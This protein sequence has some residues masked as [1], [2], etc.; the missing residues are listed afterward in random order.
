[1]KTTHSLLP[2]LCALTLAAAAGQARAAGF[3]RLHQN[4]SGLGNAFAGSAAVAEDASTIHFNPAG[5][6]QLPDRQ[7]VLAVTG[8]RDSASFSDGGS[9]V[10]APA[11][12]GGNGGNA[13]DW[14][15]LA[16]AY[17]SFRLTP[18]LSVGL[19]AGSPFGLRTSYDAGWAGRFQALAT[20]IKTVSLAPSLA[21][22][23]TDKL[24]LG[25]S[26]IY[27]RLE[28]E[29]TA[30][31][32]P[33]AETPLRI[34]G[35][36]RAWGAVIGATYQLSPRMRVGASYRTSIRHD[37][38]GTAERAVGGGAA[39]FSV[40]TPDVFTWSVAQQISDKWE[41]LGDISRT[42]WKKNQ[43]LEVSYADGSTRSESLGLRPAWRVA[44]GGNYRYNDAWKLRMGVAYERSAAGAVQSPRIPDARRF[45]LAVGAQYRVAK[46]GYIDLS[47]AHQFVKDTSVDT[48]NGN[49]AAFGRLLG[50]YDASADVV[51]IQYTQGF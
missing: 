44:L 20:D 12:V 31:E 40:R 49:A 45:W 16:A 34:T 39:R 15:A 11:A 43:P 36:D 35:S 1:M 2:T 13:G 42:G 10:P 19:G 17:L 9:T 33:A 24:S 27:Q 3:Q 38:A 25:A 7:A 6:S 50:R 4:A 14:R 41:M 8:G 18:S 48:S 32:T 29:F 47:Y 21:W 26:V 22:R 30:V 51:G 46:D 5:M 23:A 37:V 28:A